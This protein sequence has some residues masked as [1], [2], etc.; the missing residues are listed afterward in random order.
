M[1]KSEYLEILQ[2]TKKHQSAQ[3]FKIQS[4]IGKILPRNSL[5]FLK[6]EDGDMGKLLY[7]N[8]EQ[9]LRVLGSI[10]YEELESIHRTWCD[11]FM[12][13]YY[14]Y[15]NS[16]KQGLIASIFNKKEVVAFD[17]DKALAYY[18]DLEQTTQEMAQSIDKIYKRLNALPNSKFEN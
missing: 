9:T 17:I 3:L 7:E 6:I 2:Q 1:D 8:K 16:E 15:F 18:D 10:F 12:K 14:I 13:I 11:E 5:D 4:V